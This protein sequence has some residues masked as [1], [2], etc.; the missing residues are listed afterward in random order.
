MELDAGCDGCKWDGQHRVM[1]SKT[2]DQ[3]S[4]EVPEVLGT[5]K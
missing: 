3:A 5:L 1:S 4:L 2:A